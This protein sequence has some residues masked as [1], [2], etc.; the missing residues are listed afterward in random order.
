M[1]AMKNTSREHLELIENY[2][3]SGYEEVFVDL[4][5]GRT[6]MV[7]VVDWREYDE[8]IVQYCEDIL[9]TKLLTAETVDSDN[10][11]GF[12]LTIIYKDQRVLVPYQ[13]DGAD[14]DTT[15][16]YLNQILKADYEIRLCNASLG[17]D[18]LQFLPLANSTWEKLERR[19]GRP[20]LENCFTPIEMDSSFFG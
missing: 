13:G 5:S 19:W 2:L 4:I 7:M 16:I 3:E 20:A 10:A 12:E 6:D 17:S 11:Q 8:V 14:R 1:P 18:T 9:N 15:I